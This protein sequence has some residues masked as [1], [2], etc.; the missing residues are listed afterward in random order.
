MA[1]AIVI[2]EGFHVMLL[3]AVISDLVARILNKQQV[4]L[5][6]YFPQC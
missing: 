6:L 3:Y 2:Y 4:E 5:G 1:L